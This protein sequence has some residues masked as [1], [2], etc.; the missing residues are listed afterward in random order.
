MTVSSAERQSSLL[1][2]LR[3]ATF[4]SRD[5]FFRSALKLQ[6]YNVEGELKVYNDLMRLEKTG[7]V[8][9]DR[10]KVGSHQKLISIR[11]TERGLFGI[12]E[13]E[14][15]GVVKA[16]R[17]DMPSKVKEHAD[18]RFKV[19]KQKPEPCGQITDKCYHA[20]CYLA[21]KCGA[22]KRATGEK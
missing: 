16:N 21:W 19:K 2:L 5:D 12:V 17:I 1:K 11:L 15:L 18:R 6:Y 22:R 7:S 14:L 9:I 4:Q 3:G 13:A 20:G 8:V 10:V